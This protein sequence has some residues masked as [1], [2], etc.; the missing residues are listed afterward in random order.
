MQDAQ[1]KKP[2]M[3]DRLRMSLTSIASTKGEEEKEEEIS[4]AEARALVVSRM[5]HFPFIERRTY[6]CPNRSHGQYRPLREDSTNKGDPFC[7]PCSSSQLLSS[8]AN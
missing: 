5:G 8:Q 1:E 2:T 3:E 4:A 7:P 6:H